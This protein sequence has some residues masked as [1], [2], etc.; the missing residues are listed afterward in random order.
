[1]HANK[2]K[3]AEPAATPET[4]PASEA[5]HALTAQY[6]SQLQ[7]AVD[8]L[9]ALALRDAK[10]NPQDGWRFDVERVIYVKVS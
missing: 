1:M 6:K 5:I 8:M 9:G 4:L 3:K 2:K 7:Q 10:L